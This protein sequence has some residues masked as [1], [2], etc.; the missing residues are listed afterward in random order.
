MSANPIYV[1]ATATVT[2]QF[3]DKSGQAVQPDTNEASV[4]KPDGTEEPITLAF[5]SG[6]YTAYIEVDAQ[7][8]WT[9]Q[10][11]GVKDGH[12]IL[13]QARFWVDNRVGE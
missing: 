6:V 12:A 2:L 1:G 5:G 3:L 13:G 9:V 4:V 11:E 10:A 8:Y 7:G